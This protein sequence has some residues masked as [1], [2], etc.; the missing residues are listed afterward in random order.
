MHF[1]HPQHLRTRTPTRAGYM[2]TISTGYSA[3]PAIYPDQELCQ[4]LLDDLPS[5]VPLQIAKSKIHFEGSGLIAKQNILAHTD[6]YRTKPIVNCVE[7]D[8]RSI[9]C[10][11]CYIS[12]KTQVLPEGRFFT[13][14]DTK[15]N[16]RLCQVCGV[17]GY[18]SK[19]CGP[20]F[21]M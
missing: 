11:F 2:A 14:N 10:D 21:L 4:Y 17:C 13:E 12:T 18:C 6:I 16:V 3:P 9:V 1:L 5:A 20:C 8:L 7:T 19:L 15:P